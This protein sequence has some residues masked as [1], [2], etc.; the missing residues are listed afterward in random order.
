MLKRRSGNIDK[1]AH[2]S[3]PSTVEELIA[4]DAV[5]LGALDEGH[6][7]RK[8]RHVHVDNIVALLG[9]DVGGDVPRH[10]RSDKGEINSTKI[11]KKGKQVGRRVL[12]EKGDGV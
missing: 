4:M 12:C 8:L 9:G 7:T 6:L 11:R 5:E 3:I 10:Q 2:L 1:D